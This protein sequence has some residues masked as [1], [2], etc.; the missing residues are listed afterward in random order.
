MLTL[1]EV[2]INCVLNSSVHVI[3]VSCKQSSFLQ[4]CMHFKDLTD[5]TARLNWKL[6]S[7]DNVLNNAQVN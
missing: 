7:V 4:L 1:A 6:L 2:C 5:K 3:S